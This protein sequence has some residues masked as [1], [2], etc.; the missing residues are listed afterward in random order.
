V[1]K[2]LFDWVISIILGV[3]YRP[4]ESS[5][6]HHTFLLLSFFFFLIS[7]LFRSVWEVRFK[8][9]RLGWNPVGSKLLD[10]PRRKIPKE[11]KD[12]AFWCSKAKKTKKQK[13]RL[14][15]WSSAKDGLFLVYSVMCVCVIN[16]SPLTPAASPGYFRDRGSPSS[17]FVFYV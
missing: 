3:F 10:A 12:E 11:K 14:S 4:D 2:F 6:L 9:S 13:G 7:E 17:A 1:H 16:P 8:T 5:P 15:F